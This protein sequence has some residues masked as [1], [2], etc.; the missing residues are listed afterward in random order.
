M[1]GVRK[2]GVSTVTTQFSGVFRENP[3]EQDRFL[4]MLRS[5]R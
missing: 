2:H 1:R 3:H 4:A 5:S